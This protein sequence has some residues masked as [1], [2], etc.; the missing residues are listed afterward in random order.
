MIEK[1]L[2]I[3]DTET[4]E[5]FRHVFS[6]ADGRQKELLSETPSVKNIDERQFKL[7]LSGTTLQLHTK[8]EGNLYYID[9]TAA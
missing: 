7:Y 1:P 5:L 4:R 6:E 2:T 9:F 3:K 8:Y